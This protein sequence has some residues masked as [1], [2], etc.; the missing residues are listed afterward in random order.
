MNQIEQRTFDHHESCMGTVFRF[1]GRTPLNEQDHADALTGA[2]AFLHSADEMFSLYK[3]ESPLSRLARG[4]TNVAALDPI[5]DE[6]W[7]ACEA[8]SA[9]TDGWFNAFTPDRT[10][11]PSGLVKT[12]AA[13]EAARRLLA[14]GVTDF[15][16]NAGGDV[17]LSDGVTGE[18]SWKVGISK[19]I[20]IASPE[21]GILTVFDLFN[22]PMRA[23]ATSG[24]A[25][26]GLHIWNPRS[27]EFAENE[28][29]QVTVIAE[30][31]I[32]ADVWAT[33]AFAEGVDAVARLNRV[34]NL[35]A[36]FVLRDG[37][38]AGTDGLINYFAKVEGE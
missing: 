21:A 14:A 32:K 7:N 10:F 26:R 9:E 6:I 27:Y 31:L 30:D 12:W 15:A 28:L 13:T 37:G 5:V 20:T 35:E 1:A 18:R 36:L 38:L 29:I 33:A 24:T 19:P 2:C 34:P 25:E 4:E 3:P 22:S 11:D 23:V 17:W 8:W 16:V